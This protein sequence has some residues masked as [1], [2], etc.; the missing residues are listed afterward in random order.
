MFDSLE[1]LRAIN[2]ER[3]FRFPDSPFFLFAQREIGKIDDHW[4]RFRK[5]DRSLYE[6][7]NIGLMCARELEAVDPDYCTAVYNML[8]DMRLG[9]LS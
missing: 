1:T 5:F 3:L 7:L 8:E 9:T 2:S 6:S 4:Q